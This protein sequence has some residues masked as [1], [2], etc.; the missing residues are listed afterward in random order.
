MAADGRPGGLRKDAGN[1]Q[2][3]AANC[4][5]SPFDFIDENRS[6]A[7]LSL[8]DTNE[9]PGALAGAT[10]ADDFITS[11]VSEDY[12]MRARCATN[13]AEAIGDCHPDDAVMLMTAALIDLS[14]EGPRL[15]IFLSAEDDANWW[16]SI[17][18]PAQLLAV[19]AEVL[20]H[21]RDCALHVHMRK[22]L[23][24]TLFESLPFED[25]WAFLKRIDANGQFQ[26]RAGT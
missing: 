2:V 25:R 3:A 21:L 10:G 26:R 18:A 8:P 7:N 24:V 13:L 12:R 15:D 5:K 22:R 23:I 14:P 1:Q 16:A 19:L 11:F 6:K 9:N 20:A 4:E 17:A